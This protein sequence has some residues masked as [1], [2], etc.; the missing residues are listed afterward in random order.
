L[1]AAS[2]SPKWLQARF[3]TPKCASQWQKQEP[4]HMVDAAAGIESRGITRLL[5]KFTKLLGR[6]ES[7]RDDAQLYPIGS[8][9]RRHDR[10]SRQLTLGGMPGTTIAYVQVRFHDQTGVWLLRK[11]P[12]GPRPLNTGDGQRGAWRQLRQ[13]DVP[14]A[15]W[16]SAYSGIQDEVFANSSDIVTSFLHFSP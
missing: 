10:R 15:R 1:A 6:T 12:S 11:S 9:L 5:A 3:R 4:N 2:T 14:I 7:G 16:F 13:N 8:L